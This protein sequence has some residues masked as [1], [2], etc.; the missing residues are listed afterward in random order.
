MTANVHAHRR[1][2]MDLSQRNALPRASGW[3]VLLAI[4]I[5]EMVA[6]RWIRYRVERRCQMHRNRHILHNLFLWQIQLRFMYGHI[7]QFSQ[8]TYTRGHT[9][10]H[11]F[12][13]FSNF[14][15]KRYNIS[16]S[17]QVQVS[18]RAAYLGF[19]V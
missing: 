7:S 10:W 4:W 18:S 16:G 3:G 19:H 9:L 17:I 6:V 15:Y 2:P 11:A 8:F 14:V 5:S 1:A 12:Q 13:L